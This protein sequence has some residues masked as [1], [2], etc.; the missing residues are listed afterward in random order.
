MKCWR[1]SVSVSPMTRPPIVLTV[2]L[3]LTACGEPG[4][5]LIREARAAA[6]GRGIELQDAR[7]VVGLRERAVC[8]KGAIYREKAKRLLLEADFVPEAWASLR[9]NWCEE[10]SNEG[11][12]PALPKG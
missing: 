3:A 4:S 10:A 8:A 11:A 2:A 5:P 6:A 7:T 1:G 12:T 9:L